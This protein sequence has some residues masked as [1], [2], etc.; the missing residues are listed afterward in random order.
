MVIGLSAFLPGAGLYRLVCVI[1]HCSAYF[2]AGDCHAQCCCSK[3][4][5]HGKLEARCRRSIHSRLAL[6]LW[7]ASRRH[8]LH[9]GNGDRHTPCLVRRAVRMHDHAGDSLVAALAGHDS[10]FGTRF[11]GSA[12]L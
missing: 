7:A 12:C 11:M 10:T 2:V 6:C 5:R 9:G 4:A 1:V 8:G 3:S